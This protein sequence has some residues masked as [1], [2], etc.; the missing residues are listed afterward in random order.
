M[1]SFMIGVFGSRKGKGPREPDGLVPSRLLSSHPYGPLRY[2]GHLHRHFQGTVQVGLQVRGGELFCS[3]EGLSG[4]HGWWRWHLSISKPSFFHRETAFR[5][6]KPIFYIARRP[7]DL[8]TLFFSSLDAFSVPETSSPSSPEDFSVPEAS[9]LSSLD[10][11]SIP[12]SSFFHRWM[13]F[14]FQ[15]PLSPHPAT[16][17][18]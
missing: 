18:Q 14:R 16:S 8:K 17:L 6:Q 15:K 1:T 11:L 9:S 10:G 2:F 13:L 12:K 5:F 4:G 7:F 3:R